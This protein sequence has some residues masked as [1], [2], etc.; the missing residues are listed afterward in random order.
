MHAQWQEN[1]QTP[2]QYI[3]AFNTHG[4]T[5]VAAITQNAG[6][7]V[8]KPTPDPAKS[9]YSFAGWFSAE[10]G[11]AEYDWPHTLTASLTMHAQWQENS[12]TL[13]QYTV[14]FYMNGGGPAPEPQ[15]VAAGGKAAEPAL[16]AAL[17]PGA[18]AGLYQDVMTWYTDTAHTDA[19]DFNAP[20]TQNLDLYTDGT[21][22][23]VDLSGI[24]GDHTLT[25]ALD[26]II[27]QTLSVTTNYTIVLDAGN[28][29]LP[30]GANISTANAVITLLVKGP[31]EINS[32]YGSLFSI[33]AG[34]L[35]LDN[36]ITLKGRDS[37]YSALV[38]VKGSS[39]SLTMKAGVK[40]TGNTNTNTNDG[41]YIYGGGVYVSGGSF[42]MN[43]GEI[44]GNSAVGDE[45]YGG[46][47]G[48][49]VFVSDSGSFTMNGG[50]ISGNTYSYSESPN[51]QG[52]GGGVFVSGTFTMNGGKISG[53]SLSSS[54][55]YCGGGV[56]VH[57]G[58]FTMSGGEI[59][60]NSIDGGDGG[61][62][63]HVIGTFTMSNGKISGNFINHGSGGGG[64]Y[65]YGTFTM[66]GGE[67]SG[68][69]TNDGAGGGV[70]SQGIFE[71]SGGKISGNSAFQVGG[72]VYIKNGSYFNSIFEMSGGEISGNT[73]NYGG[74]VY[75]SNGH[76]SKTG[77][78][79]IYG[80]NAAG[81]L[82]NTAGSN[83]YGYAVY[84]YSSGSGYYR[85]DTLY[86]END[87]NTGDIGWTKQ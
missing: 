19:W 29:T 46:G 53:N 85:N 83:G 3:I 66:S 8:S 24:Y 50:E 23:P 59:S 67:I 42:T 61:G 28:Y 62:G 37:N 35:V 52:G 22:S 10:T 20:V 64:V 70:I 55:Y 47:G 17:P 33:S 18:D 74:G 86:A 5:D 87:I 68:N 84:Y 2:T 65:V 27:W 76:F 30:H 6:T 75:V 15:N 73:A 9:G 78:G 40:V 81:S 56:Y 71:M 54:S 82:K 44:S 36:N 32:S 7:P 72:G 39:A 69:S 26:Y 14:T 38:S 1:S 51:S 25:K 80:S 31:T 49:G 21:A 34:E 11:G 77:G 45:Y 12:Q 79:V 58:S 60:G 43:G 57:G 48:G 41:S 16:A 63:V 4:G 13:T